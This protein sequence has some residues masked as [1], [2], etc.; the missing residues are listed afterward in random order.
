MRIHRVIIKRGDKDITV[1]V[2][3][4]RKQGKRERNGRIQREKSEDPKIVAFTQPHRQGVPADKRHD[5]RAENPF[6]R[7]N[8]INAVPDIE[9]DAGIKFRDDCQRY[10]TTLKYTW[11]EKSESWVTALGAPNPFPGAIAFDG[12]SRGGG[13]RLDG[14][15][16]GRR[17]NDYMRAFEAITGY[18]PRLVIK[19]VVIFEKELQPG[20]LP[21]LRIALQGLVKHYGLSNAGGKRVAR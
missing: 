17:R 7:L 3:R 4:K 19:S 18:G 20:D 8:L 5:Q 14:S 13:K 21:D 9:Y 6:G 2:G 10:R 16:I 1:M 15:E 11:D 12:L